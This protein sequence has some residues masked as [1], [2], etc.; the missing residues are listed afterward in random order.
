MIY[1][2]PTVKVNSTFISLTLYSAKVHFICLNIFHETQFYTELRTCSIE[3]RN[4]MSVN[5]SIS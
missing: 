2:A 4:R 3:D 5:Q 1:I